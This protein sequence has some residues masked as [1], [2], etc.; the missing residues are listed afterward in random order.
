M[1][2]TGL[3]IK[4]PQQTT[5]CGTLVQDAKQICWRCPRI[6]VPG[7]YTILRGD[8]VVFAAA[9]AVSDQE[10]DL[11]PL[12]PQTLTA[13]L[14]AGHKAEFRSADAREQPREYWPWFVGGCALLVLVE[15]GLLRSFRS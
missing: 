8:Q 12:S 11:T 3:R 2:Q 7:V 4:G 1:Q 5:D 14:A 9:A 10:S 15:W 13:R 6:S